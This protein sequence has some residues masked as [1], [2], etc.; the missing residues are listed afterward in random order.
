[1]RRTWVSV[2]ELAEV[3]GM[4]PDSVYRAYRREEIPGIQLARTIRFDLEHVRQA[5]EARAKAMPNSQCTKH[6]TAGNRRRR[7]RTI[8]PR[9]VKRGRNFQGASIRRKSS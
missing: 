7:A 1:M 8:S 2:K 9:S 6:A 4:S 5:M 3:L